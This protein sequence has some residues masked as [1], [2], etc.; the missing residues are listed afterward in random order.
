MPA[1][2]VITSLTDLLAISKTVRSTFNAP[3]WWRGH[4]VESWDLV[5]HVHRLYDAKGPLYE[6]TIAAKFAQ[7]APTRYSNCPAPGAWARWLFLM[8][9][10]GLPT[11]LLDWTESPLLAVYFAAYEDQYRGEPGA[12]WALDPFALNGLTCGKFG[13]YTPGVPDAS[14]LVNLAFA[15]GPPRD[16][17]VVSLAADEIDERM[18]VQMSGFTIHGTPRPLNQRSGIGPAVLQKFTIDALAKGLLLEELA[19]VGIRERMVFPDLEHLAKDLKR[20]TY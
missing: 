13:V 16:E 6:A 20:D 10:Y 4:A 18:M 15:H 12:I 3:P 11:R 14:R 7:F 5:P 9:H 8:Q 17:C 1:P 2:T 19:S